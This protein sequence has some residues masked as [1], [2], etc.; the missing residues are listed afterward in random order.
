[1]A[2]YT[3]S[4]GK[5]P[6]IFSSLSVT[7]WLILIN[8][9]FFIVA[10]LLGFFNSGDCSQT[11]CKYIAL[12]PNYVLHGKYL[13]T[14]LT[15]MFMHGGFAHILFNMISLF[16]VGTLLEKIIGRKR[17]FWFYIF[18]GIFAGIIFAVLAYFLGGSVLG[19]KLFGD[20]SIAGIGASG[21]IFGLVGVLAV[22]I[23]KNKISLIAGPLIAIVLEYSLGSLLNSSAL[24]IFSFL[25]SVYIFFSIFAIFSFNQRMIRW[26][27]PLT[28]PFWLLPVVA[29]VPLVIAGLFITL[30]IANSAHFGGLIAG[31][32]YGFYLKKRYKKKTRYISKYFS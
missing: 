15:S 13:W 6:G 21:A 17:Y 25:L 20:P 19:A 3:F 32:A 8:V 16:F 18:A 30:P 29:I 23:P 5:K 7:T 26:T 2:N 9:I 12:T 14:F 1:M 24:A 10:M 4:P 28:M 22:L 27:L 11:I 31:I